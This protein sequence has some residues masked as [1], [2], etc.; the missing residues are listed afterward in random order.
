MWIACKPSRKEKRER[1]KKNAEEG[2]E[3]PLRRENW[4]NGKQGKV[5]HDS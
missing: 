2:Q 5:N 4:G 1:L 3:I